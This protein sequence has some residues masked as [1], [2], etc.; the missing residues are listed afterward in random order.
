M[1]RQSGP[2]SVPVESEPDFEEFS[3]SESETRVVAFLDSEGALDRYFEAGND[4]R[5]YMK[6]GH[7]T[8]REVARS[9]GAEMG[10]V[11]IFHPRS[12][13]EILK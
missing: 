6:L 4:V 2:S 12:V 10:S 1:L 9:I 8:D 13:K 3:S 7:C 11:L 5:M